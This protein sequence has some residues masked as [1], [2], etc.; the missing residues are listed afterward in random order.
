MKYEGDVNYASNPYGYPPAEPRRRR[1]LLGLGASVV[2]IAAFAG[3]VLYA[4]KGHDRTGPDGGPPLLE[5][6]AT[7]TKLRPEQPGGMEVPHQ[8]KLVFDRLNHGAKDGKPPVEHLLPAPEAPLPRPVVT[9]QVPDLPATLPPP[10]VA[11][12]PPPATTTVPKAPADVLPPV[13]PP[14]P[15]QVQ[16]ALPPPLPAGGQSSQVAA[17]PIAPPR[18]TPP[19]AKTPAPAPQPAV[20]APSKPAPAPAPQA[21]P[22]SPQ[23]A[24]APKAPPAPAPSAGGSGYRVQLASV[25]SEAEAAAEW[26]RLSGRHSELGGLSMQVAKAD[27]GEKGV[28][29]R[30]QGGSVDEARAKSICEK[31]KAQ[32]V[33]CVV[34]RP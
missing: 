20:A 17:L 27:L 4:Y 34:V 5:A 24:A 10:A 28:Y 33:G 21:V 23:P 1:G 22:Q 19:A 11:S 7:P 30:V 18:A 9:P 14:P 12:P 26:K 32:N 2:G 3:V 16:A 13:V 8:D 6:D 31:L 15:V 25:R 29:Y